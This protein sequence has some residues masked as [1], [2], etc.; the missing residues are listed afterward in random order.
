MR[1]WLTFE[2]GDILFHSVGQKNQSIG[3]PMLSQHKIWSFPMTLG[4]DRI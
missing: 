3:V 2:V 1:E 4:I